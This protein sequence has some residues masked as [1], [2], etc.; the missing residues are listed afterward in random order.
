[1]SIRLNLSVISLQIASNIQW[2][3]LSCVT[4]VQNQF[5]ILHRVDADHLLLAETAFVAGNTNKIVSRVV[6]YEK[7]TL[8]GLGNFLIFSIL[9]AR[10][11]YSYSSTY[12]SIILTELLT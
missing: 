12:F 9:S 6:T 11:V 5:L 4:D 1:M 2:L 10:V 3:L 8:P 7:K